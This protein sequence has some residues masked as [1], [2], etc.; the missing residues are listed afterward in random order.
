[1][2]YTD[3][4][5]SFASGSE[6]RGDLI[7][8]FYQRF[9]GRTP[10][11]AEVNSTLTLFNS[12]IN[13][14]VQRVE[15]SLLGSAEYFQRVGSNN[16]GFVTGLYAAVLGRFPGAADGPNVASLENQL[17]AGTISRST[18]AFEIINS[19]ESYTDLQNFNYVF[20]PGSNPFDLPLGY[21]ELFL[22]RVGD[23]TGITSRTAALISGLP[24]STA[25]STFF[26]S[27]EYASTV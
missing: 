18:A 26:G 27:A 17:N 19:A 9:L 25:I 20:P 13:F 1:V 11:A 5:A 16:A 7:V 24:I 15:A 21:Y 22:F 6:Y 3:T 10:S 23:Q 8:Q 12:P 4:S 14:T 2:A